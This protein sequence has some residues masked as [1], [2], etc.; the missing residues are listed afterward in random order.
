MK[1]AEILEESKVDLVLKTF[2]DRIDQFISS[3]KPEG[4]TNATEF[5]NKLAGFD[6]TPGQKYLPWI[7][8]IILNK[9]SKLEDGYKLKDYLATF[10][11]AKGRLDRKDINAYSG[12]SDLYSAIK[13]VDQDA[14]SGKQE[15][16]EEKE[17]LIKSGAAEQIYRDAT[18]Q[19]IHPKTKEAAV[20]FGRG[21]Q[22]CTAATKSNNMFD[23]YNKLGPLYII[24][25]IGK[26]DGRYQVHFETGQ[27]MD[28]HDEPA[29]WQRF[30][31]QHP[32]LKKVF[33]EQINWVNGQAG[34]IERKIE[35]A[36]ERRQ[37]RYDDPDAEV[38]F[39][40]DFDDDELGVINLMDEDE[41]IEL[42]SKYPE[43]IERIEFPGPALQK[44]ILSKHR[45]HFNKISRPDAEHLD[46]ILANPRAMNVTGWQVQ[47]LVRDLPQE[48]Q[49]EIYSMLI[50]KVPK[51]YAQTP[52]RERYTELYFKSG[53]TLKD[54]SNPSKEE[55]DLAIQH[56]RSSLYDISKKYNGKEIIDGLTD[57]QL[58][59]AVREGPYN[60]DA[61]PASRL[62][63]AMISRILD[64][65][66]GE[67]RPAILSMFK[68]NVRK[69]IEPYLKDDPYLVSF[70]PRDQVDRNIARAV[71]NGKNGN[72]VALRYIP[73]N[74]I[75]K[76][77]ARRW[78]DSES[79]DPTYWPIIRDNVGDLLKDP[80]IGPSLEKLRDRYE[81]YEKAQ[82]EERRRR[83]Y[84]DGYDD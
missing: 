47:H 72:R 43:L 42:V 40:E 51:I 50:P 46:Q 59:D 78:L 61:I 74:M 3:S 64:T 56:S 33:S 1:I 11:R 75:D 20:C 73:A 77:I 71:Q 17:Q 52:N 66:R 6:P 8:K 15:K 27:F 25:L 13:D 35:D 57:D 5:V 76:Q 65:V 26:K 83:R 2:G 45:S 54:I 82:A 24:N 32:I 49:D 63:D 41:Q 14:K 79:I 80:V 60:Q 55:L 34:D 18:L 4:I 36:A 22:W 9:S 44:L 84:R 70:I 10:D 39:Q 12:I 29:S 81:Q 23:Q 37:E 21:T 19:V 68:G 28:V 58:I 48:R 30:I 38:D 67:I 31:N 62:N 16:R 69:L 53:G 7:A